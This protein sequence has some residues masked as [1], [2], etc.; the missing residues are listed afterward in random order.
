MRSQG[1]DTSVRDASFKG[2][3]VL[4]LHNPGDALSEGRN[5]RVFSIRDT[6]VGGTFLEEIT[7]SMRLSDYYFIYNTKHQSSKFCGGTVMKF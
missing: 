5:V 4:V 6:S 7:S 1:Q 3:D 2:H